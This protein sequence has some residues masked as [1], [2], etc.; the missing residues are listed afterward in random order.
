MEK[1]D[2][3]NRIYMLET[4]LRGKKQEVQICAA[5]EEKLK[6]R[7]DK[8][9]VHK[10]KQTAQHHLQMLSKVYRYYKGDAAALLSEKGL[11]VPDFS[12][13]AATVLV[14]RQKTDAVYCAF[15]NIPVSRIRSCMRS[16]QEDEKKS[17]QWYK[18]IAACSTERAAVS[19]QHC[20]KRE[21]LVLACAGSR[22]E[23]IRLLDGAKKYAN[24]V[25]PNCFEI[26][27]RDRLVIP[28]VW[29]SDIEY[30]IREAH[31][32][33]FRVIPL[34]NAHENS[35]DKFTAMPYWETV[36][37]QL[38]RAMK[39]YH[40]DGININIG[41]ISVQDIDT[42]ASFIRS[43][44]KKTGR[45]KI[46]AATAVLS[47]QPAAMHS[48][49]NLVDY[50]VILPPDPVASVKAEEQNCFSETVRD[51]LKLG[52]SKD[53]IV[54]GIL[55]C[56]RYWKMG[57][58]TGGAYIA[59]EDIRALLEQYTAAVRYDQ[60]TMRMNATV[61]I[62]EWDPLPKISGSRVLVPGVYDIWYD[63]PETVR[64][65]MEFANRE[66]LRGT[67]VWEAACNCCQFTDT[68]T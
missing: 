35:T 57:N 63:D 15:Q 26:D 9:W 52:V 32:R 11:L 39:Q 51:V 6:S 36:G 38:A 43:M 10:L 50:L 25:C 31:Q 16:I 17:A 55:S 7:H 4:A 29:K 66:K 48:I 68:A 61:I 19:S 27:R 28:S 56:G 12:E 65:K 20:E 53:K 64:Y 14:V 2:L 5:L 47:N 22:G 60:L 18:H 13:D 40:L 58:P 67:A 30:F 45:E 62:R 34:I 21:H 59:M 49:T 1:S 54:M 42:F 23:Y 8:I 3:Q 33:K 41:N 24:T 37:A 46:V 44:R